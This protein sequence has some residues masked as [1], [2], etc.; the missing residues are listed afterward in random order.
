MSTAQLET[1]TRN[2]GQTSLFGGLDQSDAPQVTGV[3]LTALDVSPEE[4]ATWEKELLGVPLSYNPLMALA[5]A[6]TEE[7]IN[8]VDQLDEDMQGLTYT[9]IGHVASVTERYTREQKKFLVV[10]YDLLGGTG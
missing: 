5:N 3:N 7:G 9:L 6:N 2:S 8:S 4:K 10:N 1:R